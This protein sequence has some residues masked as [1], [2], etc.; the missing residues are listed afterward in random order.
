MKKLISSLSSLIT[1]NGNEECIELIENFLIDS[2]DKIAKEESFY[3]LPTNEILK[4]IEKSKIEDIKLL[5]EVISKTCKNKGDESVLLLN[6]INPKEATFEECINILSKFVNCPFCKRT[7][8]LF[9]E[10]KNAQE[11][12]YNNKVEELKKE[13]KEL[14]NKVNEKKTLIPPITEKKARIHH[15]IKTSPYLQNEICKAAGEGKLSRV[16]YLVEECH[17][18]VESEDIDG[19]TPINNASENG[20]LEVVKYLYEQC[21]ADVE[22]KDKWNG[23]TPINIASKNGHLEV[24]KYLCKTC[25][26]DVKTKDNYGNTPLSNASSKGH[27]EVVEYLI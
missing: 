6:V 18:D 9:A 25:H 5:Y 10:Y 15:K 16:R 17:A 11:S 7:G 14:Q 2:F 12:N 13:F 1:E 20:H 27:L 21:N 3:K 19:H 22:T 24:V 26:A 8:E 23:R 4:I